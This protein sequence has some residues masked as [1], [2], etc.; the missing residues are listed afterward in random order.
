MAAVSDARP[1]E[2]PDLAAEL[3]RRAAVD[4]QARGYF[5][6]GERPTDAE[7]RRAR[8]VDRDNTAWLET[9]VAEHGWPGVRL[10]GEQAANAAWLLAQHADRQPD[11][12]R[13]WLALL[14]AAVQAGDANPRNLAYLEDRVAIHERRPQRHG[15]QPIRDNRLA[16]LDDPARVNEHRAAAGLAP[17]PAD[18][19]AADPP[20]DTDGRHPRQP[21]G[22]PGVMEVLSC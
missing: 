9:V 20:A 18:D 15:T 12:Q 13:R 4:Q 19:I 7:I 10:V 17:L 3:V 21:P 22:P 2:R 16:P 11:L 5:F 6:R 8:D 1:P 14:R